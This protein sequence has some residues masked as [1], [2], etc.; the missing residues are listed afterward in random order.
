[1]S[2]R[3]LRRQVQTHGLEA[4]PNAWSGGRSKTHDAHMYSTMHEQISTARKSKLEA[5]ALGCSTV[6]LSA[7]PAMAPKSKRGAV[8]QAKRL[9][10]AKARAELG[11]R[12]FRASGV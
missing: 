8:A 12:S 6:V 3:M 4:C 9:A 2:K 11:T 7:E 10:R 1:M 5:W